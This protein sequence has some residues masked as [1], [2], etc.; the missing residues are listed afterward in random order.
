MLQCYIHIK[1]LVMAFCEGHLVK[2]TDDLTYLMVVYGFPGLWS[3]IP[4]DH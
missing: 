3:V 1:C 2:L 4:P